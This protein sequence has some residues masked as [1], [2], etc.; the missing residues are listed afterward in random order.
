MFY[1][2]IKRYFIQNNFKETVKDIIFTIFSPSSSYLLPI[3]F[4]FNSTSFTVSNEKEK[5]FNSFYY[6]SGGFGT[7]IKIWFKSGK[8]N[9]FITVIFPRGVKDTF[10]QCLIGFK[11]V[12]VSVHNITLSSYITPHQ[13]IPRRVNLLL[14]YFSLLSGSKIY[15]LNFLNWS[16]LYWFYHN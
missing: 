13:I 8:N 14:L 7:G 12:E 5:H 2:S 10:P 15:I 9:V 4:F 1:S 16:I 6:N 11:L 3:T